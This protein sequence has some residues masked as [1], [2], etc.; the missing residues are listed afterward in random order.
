[1]GLGLRAL[2]S[3]NKIFMHNII[4]GGI[5]G[6]QLQDAIITN[7]QIKGIGMAG[8]YVFSGYGCDLLGN[9]VQNVEAI[10]NSWWLY[11]WS[12]WSPAPITLFGCAY[13]T[14]VGGST[15]TNVLDL[16]GYENTIVGINNMNGNP[17]GQDLADALEQ[18]HEMMEVFRE[19]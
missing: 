13:F 19:F 14:V 8:I 17:P 10:P 2:V 16:G 5:W 18:K 3:N 12:D 7:N 9:N 6:S 1:M 15:Q 4:W 11:Y